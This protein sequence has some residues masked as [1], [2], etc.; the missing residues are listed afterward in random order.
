MVEENIINEFAVICNRI[1]SEYEL[2]EE[3]VPVRVVEG[4]FCEEEDCFID[5]D[6]NVY[7]HMT[8]LTN[9]GNVYVARISIM[10]ALK[11]NPDCT[12]SQIKEQ[13]LLNLSKYDFFKS[14]DETSDEFCRIKVRN[15]ETGEIHLFADKDVALHYEMID[16]LKNN[17]EVHNKKPEANL[18]EAPKETNAKE[19][20]EETVLTPD[21]IINLVKKTIKGQDEAIETIVTLLW[22]KYN[23]PMINKTN[24]L[25][26]GPSGVGKTAIFKKI[27]ELLNVPLAIYSVTGTS[28]AGY[29]GHDIEEM[30]SQLYYDAGSDIEKAE[31]GIVIIDEFDKLSNNRETGDIGTTAIQNELLKLIEGCE[32]TV[33]LD[34]Y[35]S[36]N[37]DTSNIVFVGCGAFADLLDKPVKQMPVIGFEAKQ[38]A[39]KITKTKVDTELIIEK[40]GIIRELAG[41]LPVVIQLNDLNNNKE[42]LKDILV[43]SDESSLYQ[44]IASLKSIGI[45]IE[46]YD[47]IVDALVD[48]AI[49][50]HIGARGL[51]SASMNM[52]LKIFKEI[53]N[54]PGKYNKLVIGNNIMN[55]STD[56]ELVSKPVKKKTRTK[57]VS[58]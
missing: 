49:K 50:K 56:Y 48:D 26:L 1:S 51:T 21:Q 14:V 11:E 12:L 30:L 6:Q 37:I 40:G 20:T 42:V 4:Y 34:N 24:M 33:Q 45:E 22:V 55:D 18:L 52:F 16:E 23:L 53:A 10:N 57:K 54:N 36:I 41:R 9:V 29:K 2:V 8:S 38:E 28:Q 7:L 13:L 3:F 58:N 31:N 5:S 17:Y 27:K 39:P 19:T 32:R 43:N 15:K 47:S 44:I 46:N 35:S 25:V